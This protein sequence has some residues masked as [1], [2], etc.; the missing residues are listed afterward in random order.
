M[1]EIPVEDQSQ[2]I[3]PEHEEHGAELSINLGV[4]VGLSQ[5][6]YLIVN[7]VPPEYH[8]SDEK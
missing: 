5:P 1:N 3:H 7:S 4:L 2:E 6:E 8:N